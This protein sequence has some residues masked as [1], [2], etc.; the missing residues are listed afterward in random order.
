MRADGETVHNNSEQSRYEALVN[1]QPAGFAQYRT[2]DDRV[3]LFHTEVDD[4]FEGQGVGSALARA[5]AHSA[6]SGLR[7]S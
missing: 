7:D 2:G 6:A 5:A 4:R 3:T 1:D